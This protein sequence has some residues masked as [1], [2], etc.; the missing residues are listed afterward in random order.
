MSKATSH[1]RASLLDTADKTTD[2]T[3]GTPLILT[4]T[5]LLPNI[6]NILKKHFN[7]LQTTNSK[8]FFLFPK[9]NIQAHKKLENP[10]GTFKISK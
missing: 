4:Y 2:R 6:N 5:P 9:G 7:I 1:N 3:Q 10:I 8:T